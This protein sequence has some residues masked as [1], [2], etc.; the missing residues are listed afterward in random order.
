MK[1]TKNHCPRVLILGGGFAGI[2]AM[3]N[4]K[5]V[6]GDKIDV[7]IC[8]NRETSLN[9]PRLPEVAMDGEPVKHVRFFLQ[10]AADSSG[11][12]FFQARIEKIDPTGK[13]ILFNNGKRLSYDYLI[14]AVGV[15]KN[16][17]ATPG[18]EEYGYSICD[19]NQAPRLWERLKTFE[20]G[21]IVTGAVPYKAGT[22]IK[23]PKLAT[24]CEGPIGEII[25]MLDY[26]LKNKGLR[27]KSPITVFTPADIFFEDVGANVHKDAEALLK[28]HYI[29][30]ITNKIISR[31]KKDHVVFK[32]GSTMESALTIIIPEYKAH[33]FIQDAGLGDEEG[34]IPTDKQMRHLDYPEIFAA[35]D[36]TALSVPKLGH[37]A[38]MQAEIAACMIAKELGGDVEIPEYKPAI[39][40]I[41][42]RGPLEAT[43]I[44]STYLFGGKIDKTLDGPI[45]FLMKWS[46][47]FY[48][49]YTLGHMP[50]KMGEKLLEKHF[51]KSEQLE[52]FI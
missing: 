12:T 31:I 42:N 40:C 5:K 13:K 16:Y 44:Y 32:D 47:D 48:Y 7:I 24:P 26:Y 4:L 6:L 18:F 19:D 51:E 43:M 49:N 34:F 52:N 50:P 39:L 9:K 41:M 23:A 30:V 27:Q 35:G 33:S 20:G 28:Q 1:T 36:A 46:F 37:L 38:V 17:S 22:R 10:S 14:I 45:P 25:F 3:Q 2:T 8:D 21:P 15:N 29:N 11:Y